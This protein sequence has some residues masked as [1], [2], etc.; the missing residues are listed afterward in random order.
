MKLLRLSS[1]ALILAVILFTGCKGKAAK[2]QIVNKWKLTAVSGEGAKDMSD[3]EKAGMIGKL[4]LEFTKDGKCT[5]SGEGDNTK[6]G[7]Y[8][9]SDDGKT[10]MMTQEGHDKADQMDVSEL[11]SGKL[12]MTEGKNKTTMTFEAK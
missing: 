1:L 7:T 4:T 12:V 8:T 10:L 3:E 9:M 11:S 6:T 2:D 5:M